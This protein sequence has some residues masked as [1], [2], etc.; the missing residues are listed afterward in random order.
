MKI[1]KYLV[2]NIEEAIAQIKK[3]L[4][5]D[6][7]ILSQKKVLKRGKLN[8]SNVEMIEVTAAV[9]NAKSDK[10]DISAALLSKK[11][12]YGSPEQVKEEKEKIFSKLRPDPDE[13]SRS[14]GVLAGREVPAPDI[15]GIKDELRPL[16]Q[17]VAEIKKLLRATNTGLD[18]YTEFKGIFFDLY[19]DLVENGVEKKLAGKLINTLQYQTDADKISDT[20]LIRRQL[21]NLLT[22]YISLPAPLKMEKG[23]R[24]VI[25]LMGPTGAGKTTT[26]AKLAS[27]FKLMES[28]KIALMTIDSYRIGAEAHLRTYAEILDVP[29]YSVYNER[30]LRLRLNQLEGY[31]LIFIDTTGRSPNDK[32]GLFIMEKHLSGIPA[33]EKEVYLILSASTK[34]LDLYH[35][36]EKYSIF[37][38][39]KFIFSKID[40]SLSLGNIFNLKMKT[41]IPV[42]YFTTG[43]RVPEDI[44]I[45]YPRKF[46]R[47]V[48]LDY[49]NPGEPNDYE[50]K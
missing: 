25:V 29:F 14:Q 22:S 37:K 47:R 21:F 15:S 45:A 38:P 8:L 28:K 43:Q 39:D 40:E 11:Y 17:D 31:D 9:E 42:A 16:T 50:E 1:K 5:K 6:A 4:G 33:E 41:D 27:Y 46:A 10:D 44:E 20:E 19:L 2:K 34:S 12:N 48:F 32:K 49:N 3:D 24:K 26:I 23:K 7:Y 18:G 35:T 30:D 36:Y 13:L